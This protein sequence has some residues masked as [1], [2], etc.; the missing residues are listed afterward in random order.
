MP[1][2]V[3]SFPWSGI[4]P[5]QAGPYTNAQFAAFIAQLYD[6]PGVS[7]D[8][9]VSYYSNSGANLFPSNLLLGFGMD[10]FPNGSPNM[11]VNVG[12]GAAIVNGVY[13]TSTGTALNLVV[14]GNASGNPRIDTVVIHL[15]YTLQTATIIL[16]TGTPAR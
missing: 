11:S 12:N 1:N 10:V 8:V 5:G 4:S 3:L 6:R 7:A 13:V 9:G 14:S 15:D 2:S 16:L